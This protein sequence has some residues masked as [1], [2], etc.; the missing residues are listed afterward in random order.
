M[1]EKPARVADSSAATLTYRTIAIGW[2]L[3]GVL[4]VL[5]LGEIVSAVPPA[6]QDLIAIS[7]LF[8]TLIGLL[9]VLLSCEVRGRPD[10][11][12]VRNFATVSF[13]PWGDIAGL[14]DRGALRVTLRN[15][16]NV[17]MIAT[18]PS[19][20]EAI[21]GYP[22]NVRLAAYIRQHQ[23]ASAGGQTQVRPN[24]FGAALLAG[25]LL[26]CIGFPILHGQL[27]GR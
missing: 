11:L 8:G 16:K 18:S 15:G 14:R 26:F 23:S 22:R 19:P 13:I 24:W 27:V 2:V 10:G 3:G 7:T 20:L 21:R 5:M 4:I 6:P 12:W 17:S 1:V 25:S 9:L